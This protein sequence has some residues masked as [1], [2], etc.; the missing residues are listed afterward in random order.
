MDGRLHVGQIVWFVVSNRNIR[1]AKIIRIT[2]EFYTIRYMDSQGGT[3]VRRSRLF[4][5]EE[6]AKNHI[7][8]VK[9]DRGKGIA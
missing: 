3:R 6:E 2:G 5:S 7:A 1:Q 9:A 4:L 8:Q